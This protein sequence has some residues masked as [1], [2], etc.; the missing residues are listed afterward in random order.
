MT[1]IHRKLGALAV[2]GLT[3]GVSMLAGSV[4]LGTA[5]ADEP[6][7]KNLTTSAPTLSVAYAGGVGFGEGAVPACTI[8]FRAWNSE[9]GEPPELDSV[10]GVP[11]FSIKALDDRDIEAAIAAGT[12]KMGEAGSMENV[13]VHV[14]KD[15]T[16]SGKRIEI[17]PGEEPKITVFDADNLPEGFEPGKPFTMRAGEL[18]EG[19]TPPDPANCNVVNEDGTITLP[20]GTTVKPATSVK[21]P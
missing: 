4:L 8:A 13:T 9:D 7:L 11:A 12:I 5:S 10:A 15:G 14:S 20:D 2:L 17:K 21:I 3:A 19:F 1:K 6:G 16:V 18:P